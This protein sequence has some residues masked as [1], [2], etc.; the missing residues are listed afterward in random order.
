MKQILTLLSILITVTSCTISEEVMIKEDG[1]IEVVNKWDIPQISAMM[2]NLSTDEK[3]HLNQISNQESNYYDFIEM[4]T[5]LDAKNAAKFEGVDRYKEDLSKLDFVKFRLDLRDNFGVIVKNQAK[6]V[7]QF[8]A[9]NVVIEQTFGDIHIKEKTRI[10]DKIAN[11]V[12]KNG[13]KTKK[14]MEEDALLE[15][16]FSTNPLSLMSVAN[17]HYNGNTFKKV[18][19]HKKFVDSFE[20][21]ELKDEE[22]RSMFTTMVK[23]MKLKLKY[24]FPKKIKSI[25]I[26]DAMLTVDGKSFIKEYTFDELINNENIGNFQVELEQ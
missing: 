21:D 9:N 24:T 1:A 12:K 8:N 5:E 16:I 15:P 18:I 11:N 22:E 17:Y 7:E 13:K 14:Q 2:G 10:A 19:N 6:S 23:Q 4:L 20:L 3:I 25:D 26:P